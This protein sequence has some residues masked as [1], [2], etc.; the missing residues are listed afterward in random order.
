MARGKLRLYLGAAPGV[1]KTYAM[2]NEGWRRKERGTDVVIGWVAGARAPPYRR[3]DPRSGDLPA[4]DRRV[5]WSGLRGDGRRRTAGAQTGA[6]AGR[7]TRSLQRTRARSTPKRWQD[8]EEL[9]DAGIN[10]ISTV[11][12]Q[13]LESLNDVVERITGVTQQETVPDPVVRNADQIEL[14]DMAPEALRRRL[15]H[16]NVYP[17]GTDRCG[18]GEL[19]PHR[20]PHCAAG[21][22][23]AVGRRP[24]RRG[25][26]RLPGAPQHRRSLG[27]QG[28]R[29]CLAHR[30]PRQRRAH[31]AGSTH[32][33]ADQ[34]R[35]GRGPRALGRHPDQFR[36]SGARAEPRAARRSRR[37]VRRSGRQR[38]C[39]GAGAGR[40]GRKR[41]AAGHGSHPPQ[42]DQRIRPGLRHQLG[43]PGGRG[44]TGRPCHRHRGRAPGRLRRGGEAL[45]IRR[46]DR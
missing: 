40:P 34:G 6:G 35:T 33:H 7:R 37:T 18:H 27:D 13:H 22:G 30:I 19:F 1:G 44:I 11:N 28:A 25:A 15:A 9:L 38:C 5:P 21:T 23:A 31:P 45:R 29:R 42:S 46:E 36:N 32:G 8:V 17:L 10:V 4:S 12:L 3:P 16:G 43:H 20:K 26:Q 41:H 2:L 14:V 39:T 24:G